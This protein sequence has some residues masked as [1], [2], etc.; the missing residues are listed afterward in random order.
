MSEKVTY[1]TILNRYSALGL[2]SIIGIDSNLFVKILAGDQ[3]PD[4]AVEQRLIRLARIM[5][6]QNPD[7]IFWPDILKL[8]RASGPPLVHCCLV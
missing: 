5:E 7:K 8:Y 3:Q 2:S 4:K 6:V 1:K